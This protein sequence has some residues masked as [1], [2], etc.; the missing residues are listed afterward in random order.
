MTQIY[1]TGQGN[2]WRSLQGGGLEAAK[3]VGGLAAGALL[4]YLLDPERGSAR[5]AQSSAAVRDLGA[6]TSGALGNAWRGAGERLGAVA[7]DAL[8]SSPD[9]AATTAVDRAGGALARATRAV[10]AVLDGTV[11]R[12]KDAA[13]HAGDMLHDSRQ[14][15]TRALGGAGSGSGDVKTAAVRALDQAWSR[16]KDA[17]QPAQGAWGPAARNSALAAGGLLAVTALLRRSPLGWA[18]GLAGAA[19]LTRGIANRPLGSLVPLRGFSLDQTV[20]FEKTIHIDAAPGDVYDLWA[21]YENFPRFMSHVIDVRD[22]GRRRSHWVVRGPGGS[23]FAWNSVLTEQN[24]PRRLAWRSE[25]GAE[26]PQSGSI[27]FAPHRG[28][29]LATVRMSYTPPAGMLGHGLATLLGADPQAQMD[30]DLARMK[31]YIERGVVPRETAKSRAG[32][33][34]LQ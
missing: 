13:S 21:N 27:E 26:I 32:S 24:R 25:P 12:A 8:S 34:F 30:D 18:L 16:T 20:D 28:G 7:G 9:G 1:R 5:R 10:S 22:L 14:R 29:T 11:E 17:A 15:A 33:R 31:A 4:M 23:E 3:L 6:R 2:E 19:L